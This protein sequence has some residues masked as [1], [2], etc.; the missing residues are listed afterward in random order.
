MFSMPLFRVTVE[1]GQPLQAPYKCGNVNKHSGQPKT[2][3]KI[4]ALEGEDSARARQRS[5]EPLSL[6]RLMIPTL[7]M[8]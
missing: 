2:C 1:E 4:T 6:L 3:Y 8:L 5:F 7:F